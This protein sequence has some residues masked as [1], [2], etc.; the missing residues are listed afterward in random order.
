MNSVMS[1]CPTRRSGSEPISSLANSM[2]SLGRCSARKRAWFIQWSRASNPK[3]LPAPRPVR[4][5]R[6]PP[7]LHPQSNT[8]RPASPSGNNRQASQAMWGHGSYIAGVPSSA[9]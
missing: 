8:E 7:A 2:L 9:A 4:V 6:F 1:N 5:K 3:H